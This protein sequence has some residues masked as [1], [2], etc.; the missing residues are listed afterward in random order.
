MN[1]LMNFDDSADFHSETNDVIF[2]HHGLDMTDT[3]Y[4]EYM[5][6]SNGSQWLIG[7]SNS[8]AAMHVFSQI[9]SLKLIKN[10]IKGIL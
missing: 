7:T 5:R 8:T 6:I 3:N 2:G 10:D 1:L 9:N 4:V